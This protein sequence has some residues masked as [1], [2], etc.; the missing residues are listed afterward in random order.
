MKNNEKMCYKPM[1][2]A[3]APEEDHEAEENDDVVKLMQAIP[4]DIFSPEKSKVSRLRS[5]LQEEDPE[6]Y[7]TAIKLPSE[8]ARVDVEMK[9][10]NLAVEQDM[11]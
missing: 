7:L 3:S 9:S 8:M 1:E 2:A 4:N 10:L 11:K 5:S 6:E